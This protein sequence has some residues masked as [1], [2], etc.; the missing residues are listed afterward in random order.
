MDRDEAYRR[1]ADAR[2]GRLA[3]V[4]PDGSP[5][6]VPFVFAVEGRTLYW[7]VD[8]KPKRSRNLTRLANLRAEP[9]AEV[10]V[11]GFDEDWSRLWWVRA[12]GRARQV[13]EPD[14]RRRALA[15]LAAKHPAYRSQPPD[16]AVVAIDLERWSGWSASDL[17]G[18][19]PPS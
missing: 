7:A 4:R 1:L 9:R 6:V 15:A 5:H 10:V 13:S 3:T 16:G 2:V 11:D 19:E 12:R 17:T 8:R 14:E 18:A